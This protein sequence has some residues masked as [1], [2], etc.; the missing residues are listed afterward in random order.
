MK[1]L[2]FLT[3]ICLILAHKIKFKK[4]KLKQHKKQ[5]FLLD[6]VFFTTIFPI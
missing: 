5:S 1:L 2:L 4:N 3:F 6:K